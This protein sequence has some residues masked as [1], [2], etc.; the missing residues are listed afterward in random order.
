MAQ[1][2]PINFM[3]WNSGNLLLPPI[4]PTVWGPIPTFMLKVIPK[5]IGEDSKTLGE[6]LED[7][8]DV[9]T[10]HNITKHNVALRL[11][12]TSFKGR[13]L[14]WYKSLAPNS[15]ADWYHLGDNF[16]ER[17]LDKANRSSLM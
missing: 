9:C 17:F 13:A 12:T 7:V 3:T 10:V 4:P 8:A 1:V 16:F 15:I 14:D 2:P 5:F 6:H 11:L